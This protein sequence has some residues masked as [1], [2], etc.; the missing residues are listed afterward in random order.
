MN[1]GS[2]PVS[3]AIGDLDGDGNADDIAEANIGTDT[4]SVLIGKA[5]GG[6]TQ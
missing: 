1:V 5:S 2:R 3:V 4:V 6:E